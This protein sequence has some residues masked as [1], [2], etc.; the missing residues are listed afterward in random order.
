MPNIKVTYNETDPSLVVSAPGGV[1]Y[2]IVLRVVCPMTTG[3]AFLVLCS[4]DS[5][6]YA[7][8]ALLGAVSPSAT[9]V[10]GEG[11]TAAGQFVL[12][13]STSGATPGGAAAD[14]NAAGLGAPMPPGFPKDPEGPNQ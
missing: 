9:A 8:D 12:R 13:V 2:A 5:D 3:A 1:G 4:G 6:N 11:Q 7:L 14:L 10:T